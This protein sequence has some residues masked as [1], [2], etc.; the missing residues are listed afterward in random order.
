MTEP[1][2]GPLT[3]A[4]IDSQAATGGTPADMT[5]AMRNHACLMEADRAELIETLKYVLVDEP[6]LIPRA[7]SSCRNV[8]RNLLRDLGEAQS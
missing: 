6:N 8:I 3:A 2:C 4:A 1:K 7:S 5:I